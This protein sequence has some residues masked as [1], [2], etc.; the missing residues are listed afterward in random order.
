MDDFLKACHGRRVKRKPI[1]IMRQAGRYL[2]EYRELRKK[3]G[4]MKIIKTPELAAEVTLMPLD[5]FDF[6]AGIIFSDIM[7]PVASCGVKIKFVGGKGPAIAK[8]IKSLSDIKKI[9][10]FQE[11]DCSHVSE[12][13]EIVKRAT[14]KPLIGFAGGPFT[15]ASYLLGGIPNA[16][17]MM[18]TEPEAWNALLRKLSGIV[19]GYAKM[20]EKAGVGAIQ[21]FDSWAGSLSPSDYQ[22]Y[23]MPF[24]RSVFSSIDIVSIHFSTQSAGIMNMMKKAGGDV[25]GVDWRMDIAEAWERISFSPIQGNLDPSVLL[26]TR[27]NVIKSAREILDKT[28]RSGHIF[29][30]GHGILPETPLENVSALVDAVHGD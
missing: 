17:T 13:I 12:A 30:L 3:N 16:K 25:I 9:R 10:E 28:R 2:P 18:R 5:V 29:N 19:S 21:I 1:W 14:K 8:P 7:T 4:I 27:S 20:Q 6:D 24:S 26:G 11:D 22:K 15:L 23:S